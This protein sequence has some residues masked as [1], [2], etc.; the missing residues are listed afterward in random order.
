MSKNEDQER[1]MKNLLRIKNKKI[2]VKYP[3]NDI[4]EYEKE[5]RKKYISFVPQKKNEKLRKD[6]KVLYEINENSFMK[7]SKSFRSNNLSKINNKNNQNQENIESNNK[8]D[9]VFKTQI[10]NNIKDNLIVVEE[11]LK[12]NSI[13]N[14]PIKFRTGDDKHRL[15]K[16][17]RNFGEVK[18]VKFQKKNKI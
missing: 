8:E 5:T 2:E 11:N 14:L 1:Y 15:I 9:E 12:I 6:I 10:N 13:Q 16:S 17:F 3:E 18:R 4:P 7:K